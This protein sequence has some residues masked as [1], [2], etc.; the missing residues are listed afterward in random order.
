MP[1]RA[2]WLAAGQAVVDER[3]GTC[4]PV[5]RAYAIIIASEEVVAA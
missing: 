2:S 5:H 1:A 3:G 4:R